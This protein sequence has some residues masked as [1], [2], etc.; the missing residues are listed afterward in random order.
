M[1]YA[2]FWRRF[3]AWFIDIIVVF[4]IAILFE[5][6]F[7]IVWFSITN[8]TEFPD[9]V[10]VIN[11]FNALTFWFYFA[12]MESSPQQATLGKQAVGIVVTD[13]NGKRI[14]FSKATGRHSAKFISLLTLG[15]GYFMVAFTEKRQALHD[16]ISSTQVIKR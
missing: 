11:I 10:P 14:S 7:T 8:N 1:E 6:I 15:F 12:L 5:F 9:S 3:I 13:R 4:I 2:G 16:I